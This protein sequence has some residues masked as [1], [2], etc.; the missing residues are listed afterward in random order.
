MGCSVWT[1]VSMGVIDV[2]YNSIDVGLESQLLGLDARVC[3]A[4]TEASDVTNIWAERVTI[5]AGVRGIFG[6]H[7]ITDGAPS[8]R[9]VAWM[10]N[11]YNFPVSCHVH[12]GEVVVR[13]GGVNGRGYYH[14]AGGWLVLIHPGWWSPCRHTKS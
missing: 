14:A 1:A 5:T 7:P 2:H 8:P 3:L 6:G 11:S 10:D 4:V 9:A 12:G 13:R